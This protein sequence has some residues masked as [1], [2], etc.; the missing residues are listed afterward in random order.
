MAFVH[1]HNHSHYS[2]LDGLM[3]IPDLVKKAKEYGSPA[4]GLT[5]HG[6]LYGA[7]EFYKKCTAAGIKPIIGV[8]AYMAV[9][10]RF[11][12]EAR[13]D[14]RRYHLT[15]LAKNESGYRDLIKLVTKANLEGYYYKPRMD[16]EL[17]REH[18]DGLV[19]EYQE[20]FG[21]EHYFVEIMQH[22]GIEGG[23]RVKALLIEIAR[24]LNVPLVATHDAH[25]LNA[26][27][28][29]AHHTLVAVQTNTDIQDT[30]DMANSTE[31]FSFVDEKTFRSF[32]ADAPEAVDNTLR[33]A[34]L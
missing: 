9:R 18:H 5:D 31:D 23:A 17:L 25:Y 6:N 15:L 32:F 12:K 3:K 14:A 34:E 8:E 22:P 33:V 28:Q 19:C 11:D 29:R 30:R 13:I 20:I 10:S 16:K 1:L 24:E 27:D 26:E 2:L 21:A 4:L 7:L